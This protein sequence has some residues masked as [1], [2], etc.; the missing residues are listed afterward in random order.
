MNFLRRFGKGIMGVRER[1]SAAMKN[2]CQMLPFGVRTEKCA[3]GHG[4]WLDLYG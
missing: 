1:I 4:V 3:D 2:I